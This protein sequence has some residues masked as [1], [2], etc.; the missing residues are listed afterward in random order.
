MTTGSQTMPT[1]K[2]AYKLYNYSLLCQESK[3]FAIWPA[4]ERKIENGLYVSFSSDLSSV[5]IEMSSTLSMK[6]GKK[7]IQFETLIRAR[8]NY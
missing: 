3:R 7:I 6:Y 5:T 4:K 8:F 2:H 1:H